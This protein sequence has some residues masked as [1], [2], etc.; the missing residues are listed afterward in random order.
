MCWYQRQNKLTTTYGESPFDLS[1]STKKAAVGQIDRF[2]MFDQRG[3]KLIV[4]RDDPAGLALARLVLQ[5]DDLTDLAA[6]SVTILQVRQAISL[7][8]RLALT[9]RS[10]MTL[11]LV[12]QRV[13]AR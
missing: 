8:L 13:L 4:H 3:P 5:A 2:G 1:L 11:F 12:G 6:A 10:R 9:D 7:A